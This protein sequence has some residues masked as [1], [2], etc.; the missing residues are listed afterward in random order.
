MNSNTES[1]LRKRAYRRGFI[2]RKC[3]LRNLEHPDYG[4]FQLADFYNVLV[5]GDRNTGFGCDLEEIAEF[6][7]SEPAAV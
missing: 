3:R 1:A 5:L 6:L 7:E 2:M 4:T